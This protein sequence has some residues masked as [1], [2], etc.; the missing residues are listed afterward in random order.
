L[1]TS[2][3]LMLQP[4]RESAALAPRVEKKETRVTG[5]DYAAA[6]DPGYTVEAYGQAFE[7]TVVFTIAGQSSPT[8]TVTAE[9]QPS[10]PD[11]ASVLPGISDAYF[12]AR[13][14]TMESTSRPRRVPRRRSLSSERVASRRS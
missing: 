4:Q 6:G 10:F 5:P 1:T 14:A 13:T 3:Y 2:R 12:G 11:E 7:T 9:G 8:V